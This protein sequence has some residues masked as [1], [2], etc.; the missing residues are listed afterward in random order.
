MSRWLSATLLVAVPCSLALAAYESVAI[1]LLSRGESPLFPA[2]DLARAALQDMG[3]ATLY[4][5]TV[6]PRVAPVVA[7]YPTKTRRHCLI[8]LG[9]GLAWYEVLCAALSRRLAEP[10]GLA[11][12]LVVLVL[13]PV[14]LAPWYVEWLRSKAPRDRETGERQGS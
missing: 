5:I 9:L 11:V 2:H 4:A 13:I 10:P 7:T 14:M 6:T 8:M 1:F 3:L 12:S